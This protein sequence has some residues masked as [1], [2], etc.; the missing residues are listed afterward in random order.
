MF[1]HFFRKGA[2]LHLTGPNHTGHPVFQYCL[3]SDGFIH[4]MRAIQGHSGGN[5]V[6]PSVR[7]NV[8]IPYM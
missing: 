2:Y 7:D 8:A 1:L 6:D 4:H 5:N 3:N